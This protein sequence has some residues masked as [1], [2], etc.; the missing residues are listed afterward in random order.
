MR[1]ANKYDV[2][3]VLNR[4]E[5]AI[6]QFLMRQAQERSNHGLLSAMFLRDEKRLM[7]IAGRYRFIRAKA[8]TIRILGCIL[9]N[10]V[11]RG[12]L[13]MKQ[14]KWLCLSG[15]EFR[16]DDLRQQGYEDVFAFLEAAH[17]PMSRRS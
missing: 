11:G 17:A 6:V 10:A 3:G 16:I 14:G 12:A 5:S 2:K 13:Q 8:A 7:I 4:I 15:V 1:E 9:G